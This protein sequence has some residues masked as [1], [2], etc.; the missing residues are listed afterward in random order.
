MVTKTTP[1][2]AA[3]GLTSA[4]AAA[5][6]RADGPNAL[7]QERPPSPLISLARQLVH[8]FALLL[9]AAALLAYAGGMPQLAVAIAVVVVLNGV[10]AFAQEY[11]AERA[12]R[13]LRELLPTR[14]AVRR[15]GRRVLVDTTALVAGDVVL[16]RAG[17]RIS[18]DADLLEAHS[19][20][21]DESTLTGESVPVR[22]EAGARVHAGTFVT[23]GEAEAAVVATGARTRLAGIAALTR[24][25]RRRPSPLSVELH[26]VVRTIAFV[27]VAVGAAFFGATVLLGPTPSEGFLLAV[28][29]TVALVPEGLLP[30]VTLSL[31]RA[32]QRMAGRK[33]LVRR[34]EAVETLGSTTF[35]CT[36]KTGTLTRNEMTAVRV[37]TPSGTVRIEGAGYSPEGRLLG[38]PAAVDAVRALAVSAY[39]CST[40]RTR[41]QDGR[42]R[43]VG[44]PMEA[45]LHAL[46]LRAGADL[47][48]EPELRRYPFDARRR[49]ASTLTASGLHLKGAPDSVLPR[50]APVPGAED[51]L[52][53]MT[54]RGLRVL[55]VAVRRPPDLPDD[56]PAG[57]PTDPDRAER[58]L[59]LLGLVGLEDPPRDDVAGAIASCRRAGIRLAMI[60]GDHPA[61]ARAIAAAV[62]LAGPDAPVVTGAGLPRDEAGLGRLLDRDGVVVAR[63][64]PEDK[65]RI[66]KALQ[67]RGHV[68]AMTGDGVNDGPA[69]RQADIGVAMGASGTDVAREA[70]D[71]VL[72]DDHFATIVA[73]VELGRATYANIRRFLTYHLTDNVAELVPFVLW[74]ATGGALPPALGVLQILALDIGTDILPALA[75]GAEPAGHRTMD[76]RARTGRLIDRRLLGRVFGVLGP[77]EAAV[78]M[79]AFAAVLAAGGWSWGETPSDGLLSTASGTAFAT[80][81]LGQMAAALACRSESRWAGRL[82]WTG[83]PL[84]LG[85]VAADAV[86]MAVFLGI[87]PV[88]DLLGGGPPSALGWLIALTAVPAVLLA[89]AAAK[90]ARHRGTRPP[91]PAGPPNP[92]D[93]PDADA[94]RSPG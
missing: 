94:V 24:T 80:V 9:W 47:P 43:A 4:E 90:A 68:V 10:F 12:G 93:P 1:T 44:D 54:A 88:A 37:W 59:T 27:A 70:A 73:A 49:R 29:V 16:L 57:L 74:A 45:A 82:R 21:V 19:L 64:T 22:P 51:A 87:P 69:L 5:R 39:R 91:D 14:A 42:W 40:G 18:A 13:R 23:E 2:P 17:D 28:G 79:A 25:A 86:L 67:A 84:L 63:V 31:A 53:A 62:G 72:L 46:A 41:R 34:L 30:T 92:P 81:M 20:A 38:G 26:R 75:L 58:E 85:A 89:D 83:N 36:D 52:A 60:T 78:T 66:A 50:C 65:L 11:R 61:T 15:D 55:A 3:R 32:A 8:F 76:G 6:L 35:I 7:P 56:L 77:A 71:L 33:A 48:D